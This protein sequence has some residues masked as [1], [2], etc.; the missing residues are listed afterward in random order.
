MKKD[1]IINLRI[2][3]DLKDSFSTIVNPT[4]YSMSEVLEGCVLDIVKRGY[5][6]INIR[7]KL[8]PRSE[9]ILTIPY[10]KKCLTEIIEKSASKKIK[11][12][13]IF[14]SYSKGEATPN[15][16]IDI[17]I[18]TDDSFTLFNLT[19]LQNRLESAL[20]KKVDLVSGGDNAFLNHINKEK[21]QIYE[22]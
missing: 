1:A 13:S 18:D 12:A 8:K 5:I 10:I 3:K 14:G 22:R 19:E 21:I 20:G 7:S 4:G 6:P 9:P 11:S 15:S 16:D 2:N 17:Y